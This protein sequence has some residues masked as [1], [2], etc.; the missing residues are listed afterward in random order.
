MVVTV[1]G[2]YVANGLNKLTTAGAT[3][4][5]YDGRGNLTSSGATTYRHTT[6][7]RLA[8]GKGASRPL[9]HAPGMASPRYDSTGW[10]SAVS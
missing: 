5:G 6:E 1:N 9:H 8:T 2:P 3:A 10:L 4:L 7:N